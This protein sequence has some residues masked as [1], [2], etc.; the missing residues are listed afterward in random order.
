[1]NALLLGLLLSTPADYSEALKGAEKART[2]A[3]AKSARAQFTAVLRDDLMPAWLGTPWDFYGTSK[4]PGEGKIACG[5]FVSTLLEDAGAKVARVRLAQQASENI[6]KSLVPAKDIKRW[7]KRP[8][9]DVIKWVDT[10]GGP[11]V[12]VVGLDY[13]VGFLVKRAGQATEMCHSSVLE[14][15][16]VVCEDAA[17]AEAMISNY[18]VVGELTNGWFLQRWRAGK[19][20]KTRR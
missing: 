5:Y 16:A 17:S 9:T 19:R 14:P 10:R 8:V 3:T 18:T 7:S 11:R 20:F 12:Y 6:I 1:M 2:T 15:R 4:V 13:H